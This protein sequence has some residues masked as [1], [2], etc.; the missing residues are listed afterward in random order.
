MAMRYHPDRNPGDSEAE[1][2]FKEAAEALRKSL[3]DPDKRVRYDKFGHAG[4]QGRGWQC[5]LWQRGRHFA[6]FESDIFGDLLDSP[7]GKP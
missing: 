6:H 4:V 7:R 2:R 3:R 1:L 5:R